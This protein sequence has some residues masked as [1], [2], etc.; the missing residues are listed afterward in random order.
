MPIWLLTTKS[1]ESPQIP[2]VH[3]AWNIPL[4]NSWWGLQLYFELHFNWRS[5]H[6]VV[7]PQSCGSPNIENFETPT[8]ESPD[9]MPFG[10]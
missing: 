9:K 8:W 2:Y 10:C 5:A 6:K 4:E 7:G 1:L 3:V